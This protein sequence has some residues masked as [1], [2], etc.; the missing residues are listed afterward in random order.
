MIHQT[1]KQRFMSSKIYY[2]LVFANVLFFSSCSHYYYAPD[3]ANVLKLNDRH[4]LKISI[5]GNSTSGNYELKHSNFQLGYSPIKHVGVFASHFK[6]SGQEPK[7]DPLRG[8]EG[9][10]NNVG[11]GGYYFF[12]AESIL[13]NLVSYEDEIGVQSGFLFDV[14][15]GYGKGHISNFY[16]EGGFSDLDLQKYF[17]QAGIHWQGKA[18]GISYVWKTGRLNYFNGIINGQLGDAEINSLRDIEEIR[19]FPF[20]ESSLKFYMGVKYARVYLNVATTI[21]EFDNNFSHR[22]SLG[23]FGIIADLDDIYRA[24]KNPIND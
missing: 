5:S 12:N 19:E 1:P 7:D 6:M 15:G 18:L 20:R 10:L 23:S 24:I 9:H 17:V 4:D 3:E 22:T 21:S 14:Y 11:I 2:L 8:G 16:T 13:N